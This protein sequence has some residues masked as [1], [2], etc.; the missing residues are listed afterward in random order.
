MDHPL[1]VSHQPVG[2]AGS[3]RGKDA[4]KPV[5]HNQ[6][7][8]TR[9]AF[10]KRSARL[11]NVEIGAREAT[12]MND[13]IKKIDDK[14]KQKKLAAEEKILLSE[15][16]HLITKGINQTLMENVPI[17][18]LYYLGHGEPTHFE[19]Q[20]QRRLHSFFVD[21]LNTSSKD[22]E[23]FLEMI[24]Q[25]NVSGSAS[26]RMEAAAKL[27][28]KGDEAFRKY[29]RPRLL[30]GIA[31]KLAA[32]SGE[33]LGDPDALRGANNISEIFEG[34][35]NVNGSYLNKILVHRKNQ[36]R[37]KLKYDVNVIY[38]DNDNDVETHLAAH[39][40]LPNSAHLK[41]RIFRKSNFALEAY[42]DIAVVATEIADMDASLWANSADGFAASISIN[43]QDLTMT[44]KDKTDKYI[45]FIFDAPNNISRDLDVASVKVASRYKFASPFHCFPVKFNYFISGGVNV[46]FSI[47]S[48]RLKYLHHSEYFVG[49][50]GDAPLSRPPFDEHTTPPGQPK[51][52]VGVELP[53]SV[54]I[55]PGS[56]VEFIW[57]LAE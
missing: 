46:K 53:A 2:E 44:H 30:K 29:E 16:N 18:S 38:N 26:K 10:E 52:T 25:P 33:W 56:G 31:H 47:Q 34:F 45:T 32:A 3:I 20:F 11:K 50:E 37:F 35:F 23:I 21:F 36:V 40:T 22:K 4:G 42:S 14:L 39:R 9:V 28:G 19:K 55:C 51:K 54:V 27:A 6:L 41:V 24:G 13:H 5:R 15:L 57:A 8:G 43:G 7:I 1:H 48:A 17:L 12:T 49:F